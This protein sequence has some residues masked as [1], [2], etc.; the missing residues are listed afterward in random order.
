MTVKLHVGYI[1]KTREGK[2]V[3]I[4]KYEPEKPWP[5]IDS[6]GEDYWKDGGYLISEPH[7]KDII[8]PWVDEP[9]VG[10]WIGWNGG[11]CPV[12]PETVVDITYADGTVYKNAI[13][14]QYVWDQCLMYRI[15]KEYKE[16]PKPREFLMKLTFT[17][18]GIR[19]AQPRS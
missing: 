5:Y 15:I 18:H 13:A 7:P 12:H 8:G 14:G 16:P 2:R 6:D 1:G 9:T 11:E 19:C 17:R 3:E 10:Q 4:V